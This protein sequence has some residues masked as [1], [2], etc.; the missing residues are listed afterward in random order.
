MNLIDTDNGWLLASLAAVVEKN[1]IRLDQKQDLSQNGPG[2]FHIR[3]WWSGEWKDVVIDDRLPVK[4]N[5]LIFAHS[6]DVS[7]YWVALVE[8]AFAKYVADSVLHDVSVGFELSIDWFKYQLR[9]FSNRVFQ[10]LWT[11]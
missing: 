2:V 6:P 9:L 7:V 8:K 10:L 1:L 4:N 5:K 3:I 11:L